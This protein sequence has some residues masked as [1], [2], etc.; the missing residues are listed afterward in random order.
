MSHLKTGTSGIQKRSRRSRREGDGSGVSLSQT[1][2]QHKTSHFPPPP[3][4]KRQHKV[5][6]SQPTNTR[7]QF[8][9]QESF[10][11]FFGLVRSVRETRNIFPLLHRLPFPT[12]IIQFSPPLSS[13]SPSLPVF[14]K[15]LFDHSHTKSHI[16]TSQQQRRHHTVR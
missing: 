6:P 12:T 8:F 5:I 1:T 2:T 4:T 13:L 10:W 7:I 16:N 3:T 9:W 11:S 15:A 14:T